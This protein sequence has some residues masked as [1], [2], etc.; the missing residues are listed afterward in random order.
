MVTVFPDREIVSDRI[1][2]YPATFVFNAW[3]DPQ[4]LAKWWWPTGF[5]N[6]F[7]EFE[8]RAGGKWIFVGKPYQFFLAVHRIRIDR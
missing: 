2:N 8:F 7:Q 3:E 4:L 5:T 6:T 1:F